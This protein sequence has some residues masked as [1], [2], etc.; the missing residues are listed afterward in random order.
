MDGRAQTTIDFAIAMGV[1]LVALT[2]VVAFMPTMTQPFTGGQE[3]PLTADRIVAQLTDG[4]LGDPAT[5]SKL[6]TTCTMFFFNE[7]GTPADPCGSFNPGDDLTEKIGVGE[8]TFVNVTVRK[9]VAEGPDPETVCAEEP[10]ATAFHHPSD[11]DCD[12]DDT[13]MALGPNPPDVSG[14]VTIAR[15]LAVLEDKQVYLVVRVWT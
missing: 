8:N 15:R 14:S 12:S 5:P 6:N 9:D 11:A 1:F 13:L 2:T 7:S 4:Q 10:G 3:N